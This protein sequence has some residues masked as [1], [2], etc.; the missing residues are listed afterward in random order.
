MQSWCSHFGYTGTTLEVKNKWLNK[1]GT[2]HDNAA[3]QFKELGMD[4]DECLDGPFIK[5]IDEV[6][7]LEKE[8]TIKEVM[9]A[10]GVTPNKED[11]TTYLDEASMCT[12]VTT[13]STAGT[14]AK[15]METMNAR[16]TVLE[17]KKKRAAAQQAALTLQAQMEELKRMQ[18]QVFMSNW[19]NNGLLSVTLMSSVAT[20]D[21][22]HHA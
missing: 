11:K 19:D 6:E 9:A 14:V 4:I 7:K 1:R 20:G 2:Y 21:P 13:G 5:G 15:A 22:G 17:E 18:L 10:E 12:G 3:R 16:E 8:E